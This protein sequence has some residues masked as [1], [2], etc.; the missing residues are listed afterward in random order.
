M[1]HN[2]RCVMYVTI[3]LQE[4]GCTNDFFPQLNKFAE[5]LLEIRMLNIISKVT[6]Y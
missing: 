2:Q 5:K 4:K 1:I 3:Y 6:N